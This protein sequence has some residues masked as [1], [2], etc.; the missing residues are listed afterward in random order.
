LF[1]TLATVLDF[2][3]A[4][5]PGDDVTLLV[6]RR[7][8]AAMKEP[9]NSRSKHFSASPGRPASLLRPKKADR[10]EAIPYN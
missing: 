8:G 5:P 6:V 3:D 1:S 9:P 4:C 10:K 7:R 2:A